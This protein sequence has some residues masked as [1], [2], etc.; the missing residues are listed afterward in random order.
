MLVTLA[1]C[2]LAL[3][4]AIDQFNKES[5]LFRESERVDMGLWL[6]APGSRSA[7]HAVGRRGGLVRRDHLGHPVLYG[8][9]SAGAALVFRHCAID[10][11][12]PDRRYRHTGVTDDDHAHAQAARDAARAQAALAALPFAVLLAVFV[13]PLVLLMQRGLEQLYPL[14]DRMQGL[15]AFSK[16]L[17]DAPY[18]WLPIVL[19][20]VL[21]AICEELAFRGFI[22]SGLRHIGHRWRAIVISA[23]FFGITHQLL[24][25]SIIAAAVGAVIG[26]VAVQTGSIFPGML[27]HMTHNGLMIL[28]SQINSDL[29]DRYPASIGSSSNRTWCVHVPRGRCR[30]RGTDGSADDALL[31]AAKTFKFCRRSPARDHS[32]PSASG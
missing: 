25:Q 22:L 2:V 3:R 29:L 7:G 8:P 12:Q 32:S 13:H 23:L 17:G 15:E 27:F 20:A 1:C 26:Y 24:Q 11:G 5:V 16:M 30:R 31:R 19:V 6:R 14:G 28:Y 18:W 21:P 4:W 10:R 9:G